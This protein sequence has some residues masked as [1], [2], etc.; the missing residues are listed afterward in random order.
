MASEMSLVIAPE[1]AML[2]SHLLLMQVLQLMQ[3]C[4]DVTLHDAN[5]EIYDKLEKH[6]LQHRAEEMLNIE[7]G[8][9]Q[10]EASKEAVAADRSMHIHELDQLLH[11]ARKK[12]AGLKNTLEHQRHKLRDLERSVDNYK[13]EKLQLEGKLQ[14]ERGHIKR[15]TD[16]LQSEKNSCLEVFRDLASQKEYGLELAAEIRKE[17]HRNAELVQDLDTERQYNAELDVNCRDKKGN[18]ALHRWATH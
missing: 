15:I 12:V 3:E 10:D 4:Q 18:T 11:N 5:C 1:T 7:P 13:K 16:E 17:K 9:T 6:F 8:S 2:P 14:E